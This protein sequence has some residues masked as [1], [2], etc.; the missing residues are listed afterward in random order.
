MAMT[1]EERLRAFLGES[2]PSGGSASDTLF[3][4]DQIEDLLTRYGS[5]EVARREG[6]ELKAAAL[7][8]LVTTVEGSSQRKLS[9]A[10]KAALNQVKTLGGASGGRTRIHLMVRE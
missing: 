7:A 1:E 9:D 3:T 8:T 10:H 4:S 6:W 2:I 5:P